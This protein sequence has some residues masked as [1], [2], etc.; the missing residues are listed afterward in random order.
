[1]APKAAP[2]NLFLRAYAGGHGRNKKTTPGPPFS[3]VFFSA[4]HVMSAG[5]RPPGKGGAQAG[6]AKPKK[7]RETAENAE[8]A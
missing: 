6:A 3:P 2:H 7:Q 5:G 8:N 1:M 4:G